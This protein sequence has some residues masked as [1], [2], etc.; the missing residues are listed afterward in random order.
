LCRRKRAKGGKQ[1]TERNIKERRN[2]K[3][4]SQMAKWLM[5]AQLYSM[6]SICVGGEY[7]RAL[8]WWVSYGE[9]GRESS[10]IVASKRERENA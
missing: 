9:E 3:V 4:P 7:G 2:K 1:I 5:A 10:S 8:R 6:T